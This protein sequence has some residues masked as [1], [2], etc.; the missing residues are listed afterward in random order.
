MRLALPSLVCSL[1][2]HFNFPSSKLPFG[3]EP[4]LF[5]R[6]FSLLFPCFFPTLSFSVDYV[7][8]CFVFFFRFNVC[9]S[10]AATTNEFWPHYGVHSGA[11][12]TNN[13]INKYERN[14]NNN[15]NVNDVGGVGNERRDQFKSAR[16][17]FHSLGAP[18]T[19][20][21]DAINL[22]DS[23]PNLYAGDNGNATV[24]CN[25]HNQIKV[26]TK[27]NANKSNDTVGAGHASQVYIDAMNSASVAGDNV[28]SKLLWAKPPISEKSSRIFFGVSLDEREMPITRERET[29]LL[30]VAANRDPNGRKANKSNGGGS[31][32]SVRN[33]NTKYDLFM[34]RPRNRWIFNH[35]FMLSSW[36]DFTHFPYSSRHRSPLNNHMRTKVFER[37]RSRSLPRLFMR[38]R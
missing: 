32:Q 6:L 5:L 20:T 15:Y 28:R 7:L 17:L 12:H 27:M 10:C 21:T 3:F 13:K 34:D 2:T 35:R 8:F 38:N 22:S 36:Y 4:L 16:L 26:S 33:G 9:F 23:V 18:S 14:N 29:K 1:F 30:T 37:Y 31:A 19:L 25:G 11:T 24:Y